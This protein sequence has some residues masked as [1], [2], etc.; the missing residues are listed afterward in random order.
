MLVMQTHVVGKHVQRPVVGEG[1]WN[2]YKVAG[3]NCAF[4]LWVKNIVLGDEMARTRM[5]RARKK[6]AHDQVYQRSAASVPQK[7]V[8]EG[9]LSDDVEE[10]DLGQ[11]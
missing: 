4:R 11:G 2:G 6:G 9:E 1:L 3:F 5:Q 7:K 10:V 8:I